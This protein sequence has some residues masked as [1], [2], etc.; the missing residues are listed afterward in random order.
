MSE[1][2]LE[3]AD[4]AQHNRGPGVARSWIGG[5]AVMQLN[6][7]RE[8]DA[9]ERI[10]CAALSIHCD[11]VREGAIRERAYDKYLARGRS[12]GHELDDWLEAEA[13]LTD[14]ALG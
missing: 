12:P 3:A 9:Y 14:E 1:A 5:D 4:G 13:E 2:I 6:R 11:L 7:N 10:M 8:N